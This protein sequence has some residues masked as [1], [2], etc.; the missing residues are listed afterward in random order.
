MAG[1]LPQEAQRLLAPFG[2]G[3]RRMDALITTCWL[4]H[5]YSRTSS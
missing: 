4:F 2:A 3:S 5:A 1:Q